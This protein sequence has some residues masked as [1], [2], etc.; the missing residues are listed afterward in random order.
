MSPDL[1]RVLN[2][3]R[4]PRLDFQAFFG[5]LSGLLLFIIIVGPVE[6]FLK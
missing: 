3:K 2:F 1:W 4:A 5:K 6:H